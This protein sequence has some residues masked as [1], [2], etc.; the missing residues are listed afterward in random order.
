LALRSAVPLEG[1]FSAIT[2]RLIALL[3][4]PR[5]LAASSWLQ[6][7]SSTHFATSFLNSSVYFGRFCFIGLLIF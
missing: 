7:F 6:P 2:Q 3:D 5:F 4:M 1:S